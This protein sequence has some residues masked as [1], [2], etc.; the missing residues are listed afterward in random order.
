MWH[1]RVSVCFICLFPILLVFLVRNFV[2]IVT[3]SPLVFAI[4]IFA[5]LQADDEDKDS[6][7]AA[8]FARL[9]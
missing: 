2:R 4:I 9:R 5:S 8:L 1:P 7:P 6:G 3:A